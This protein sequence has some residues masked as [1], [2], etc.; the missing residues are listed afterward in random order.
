MCE[1][2]PEMEES[3]ALRIIGTSEQCSLGEV[4]EQSPLG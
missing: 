1:D 4:G 3:G 2:L